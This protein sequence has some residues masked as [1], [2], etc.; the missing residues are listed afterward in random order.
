M[1]QG[2]GST[3][4]ALESLA[5]LSIVSKLLGRNFTATNRPIRVSWALRY[6][7]S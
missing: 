5:E 1:I 4:F 7:A 2:R 6:W 3:S